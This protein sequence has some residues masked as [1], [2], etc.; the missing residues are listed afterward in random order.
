LLTG[1]PREEGDRLRRA[2]PTFFR[3]PS[4]SRLDIDMIFVDTTTAY[5]KIDAADEAAEE[6]APTDATSMT[7]R[8]KAQGGA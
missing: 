7:G 5:S 4:Y 8:Y 6:W 2:F 3:R 1:Q